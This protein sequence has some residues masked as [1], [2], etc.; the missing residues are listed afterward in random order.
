M[1]LNWDCIRDV[2]FCVEEHTDLR[3]SCTF[4]D[5][6][7][8]E[9]SL[10]FLGEDP[11]PVPDYQVELSNKYGLDVLLY[12]VRYCIRSEL[13][14]PAH[15]NPSYQYEIMDLTPAG[16]EFLANIRENSNWNHLKS[17]A[18]KVGVFSLNSFVQLGAGI[19][20][21]AIQK[22]LGLI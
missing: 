8:A 19:L 4:T 20:Q 22:N 15:D 3:N 13:L 11:E 1:Q 14:I 10:R 2:M 18:A 16:H 17:A 21:A 6:V 7:S 9:D 12:H 5:T